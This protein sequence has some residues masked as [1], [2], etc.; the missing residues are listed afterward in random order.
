[1]LSFL[2][3]ITNECDHEKVKAIYHTY[4]RGLLCFAK[5]RLNGANIPGGDYEAE[6]LVQETFLRITRYISKVPD[7]SDSKHQKAYVYAILINVI[8][9]YFS[10]YKPT[11]CLEVYSETLGSKDTYIQGFCL[12]DRYDEVMHALEQ[13]GEI[14]QLTFYYRYTEDMSVKEIA[15]LMGLLPGTVDARLRRGREKI[16]ALLRKESEK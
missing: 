9:D 7:Q 2:L 11:E 14:Y 13:L 12:S 10:E 3:T 4:Y 16:L 15:E 6:D 5:K 1:M 8:N